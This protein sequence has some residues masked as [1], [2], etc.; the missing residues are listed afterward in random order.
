MKQKI[1]TGARG[2]IVVDDHPLVLKGLVQI[3]GEEPDL[4]IRA[5]ARSSP[6]ALDLIRRTE[7]DLAIVDISLE[8][9]SD[10]I[11][12]TKSI[13]GEHPKLPVLVLSMHDESLYAERALRAGASGYLMKREAPAL[14][15][16]A[17]RKI[18]NGE[19][20]VSGSMQKSMVAAFVSA[21]GGSA[22]LLEKLTDRELEILRL[23]GVGREV[24]DIA[25]A[26][27]I[28]PK[29]VDAHRGHMKEKL[30][31]KNSRELTRYATNWVNLQH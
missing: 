4:E 2:I 23:L 31:L 13:K 28:S 26:L 20:Y 18:L 11:E 14:V 7:L 12:L 21:R 16:D 25:Q 27:H 1:G 8:G 10:G 6:V 9:S 22:S 5:E 17:V 3:L 29:T 30:H 15:V 24:R 19:M